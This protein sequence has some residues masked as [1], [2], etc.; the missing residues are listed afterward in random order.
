MRL[1]PQSIGAVSITGAILGVKLLQAAHVALMLPYRSVWSCR[2]AFT[3]VSLQAACAALLLLSQLD[4]H[5]AAAN[6]VSLPPTQHGT[7]HT[8]A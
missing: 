3:V 6:A 5:Q 1:A 8:R 7:Q 2:M 4:P